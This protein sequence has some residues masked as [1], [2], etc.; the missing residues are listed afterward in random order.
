MTA[1]PDWMLSEITAEEYANL[2]EEV[3]RRIE[4]VDGR[5]LVSPSPTPLHNDVTSELRRAIKSQCPAEWQVTT[6]TDVRMH[7]V[8][9]HDRKPDVIVYSASVPRTRVP[10]PV[11]EVLLAIEVMSPG[12]IITDRIDKPAQYAHA[13]IP[14]FWRV[15]MDENGELVI[16][17]H[18]ITP[19]SRRY[20]Q[21]GEYRT[22]LKTETPFPLEIDV[23]SLLD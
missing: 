23:Q 1:L 20:E 8:P 19:S 12:S 9:L 21:T 14:H 10:I 13:G 5:V 22:L 18:Q 4:I 17:T 7:E 3:C 11:T 15:E 6:E 2:P 16:L